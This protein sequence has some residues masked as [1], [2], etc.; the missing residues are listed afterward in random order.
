M[1]LRKLARNRMLNHRVWW[2]AP[3]SQIK[4]AIRNSLLL[5]PNLLTS[6][7]KNDK[8]HKA[9]YRQ[10]KEMPNLILLRLINL[11]TSRLIA[12]QFKLVAIKAEFQLLQIK[13]ATKAQSS[14]LI[15]KR[16]NL[17]LWVLQLK[18]IVQ[19]KIYSNKALL[20]PNKNQLW[21]K[22]SRHYRFS[23]NCLKLWKINKMAVM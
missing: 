6:N 2:R 7:N 4:G 20:R 14:Q 17:I 1:E 3:I 23:N 12:T 18:L 16:H 22:L 21:M 13:R 5:N 11:P 19:K 15:V 10:L 9:R 8:I